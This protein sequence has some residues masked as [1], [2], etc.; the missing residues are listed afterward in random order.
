MSDLC[1]VCY[2]NP[3]PPRCELQWKFKICEEWLI[4]WIR[5][6]AR[7]EFIKTGSLGRPISDAITKQEKN[8]YSNII[9]T[10]KCVNAEC[11]KGDDNPE[12]GEGPQDIQHRLTYEECVTFINDS[13]KQEHKD[14]FSQVMLDIFITSSKTMLK[15]PRQSCD[16]VGYMNPR[17]K[18]TDPLV[19]EMCHYSWNEPSLTPFYQKLKKWCCSW[20]M[21]INLFND[22]QK[23]FRTQ[24]CPGCGINIIK[25]PGCKHMTWQKCL[26]EFWWIWLG[27]YPSYQHKGVLFCPFRVIIKWIWYLYALTFTFNLHLCI[28]FEAYGNFMLDVGEFIGILLLAN[29]IS[30]SVLLV[31]IFYAIYEEW[32]HSYSNAAACCTWISFM[33]TLTYPFM[34][35]AG[36][37]LAY[38]YWPLARTMA[39]YLMWQW[40]GIIGICILVFIWIVLF[41]LIEEKV[42]ARRERIYYENLL[43][44]NNQDLGNDQNNDSLL[45]VDDGTNAIPNYSSVRSAPE[46]S[47]NDEMYKAPPML[48]RR[49]SDDLLKVREL[50][51][52]EEEKVGFCDGLGMISEEKSKSEITLEERRKTLADIFQESKLAKPGR[53]LSF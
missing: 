20:N 21:N 28:Q 14:N 34:W 42:R 35:L 4:N 43:R 18:C 40:I 6:E 10:I 12:D 38:I 32:K 8:K 52:Q 45:S 7:Y 29:L 11:Q 1:P 39:I 22:F 48:Q 36:M 17:Q 3:L 24:A 5:A 13:E 44:N 51:K 25:G 37:I 26:Y 19:C 9:E 23:V 30:L 41:K 49:L 33:L 16:Y 50:F 53:H 2:T 15:C 27:N 46:G 47:K 31:I